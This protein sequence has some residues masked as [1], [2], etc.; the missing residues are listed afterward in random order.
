MKTKLMAILN[1]TPDSFYQGSRAFDHEAAVARGIDLCRQGADILDIGGE[2]TRPGAEPVEEK[3]ELRRVIPVIKAL[4]AEIPI[5]ISIDTRRASVAQ[6]AI[7]AGATLVNDVTGLADPA[8]CRVVAS[9]NVDVCVMHMLGT[10]QTMQNNPI[11]E[12]GVVHDLMEWFKRKIDSLLRFGIKEEK[13]IIDPGIGFGKTLED[14]I[15]ILNALPQFKALG[16]PV[17]LGTSRKAFLRKILNK[18]TEELLSGTLVV[19][20]LAV[21]ND[22]DILRI[23]DVREHRDLITTLSALNQAC[24]GM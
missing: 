2:S 3:E 19:N 17:L 7:E 6:A 4:Q 21:L 1:A 11:Y 12:N 20:T 16:F 9:A 8:M 15:A 14:N 22:V 5:P 13:I 23:H 10:P 18:P 24:K